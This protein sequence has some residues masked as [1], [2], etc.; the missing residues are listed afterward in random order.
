MTNLHDDA[1]L[2]L[3]IG[4]GDAAAYRS[5]ADQHLEAI[6]KYAQRLLRSP[7]EA[8]DVAQETFLRLWTDAAS[9]TPEARVSAWLHRIAHNLC[10]DRLRKMREPLT[11]AVEQ[12]PSADRPG[13]LFARKQLAEQVDQVLHALPERQR[14]AIT[15]V[16]YQGMTNPEA[17]LVLGVGVEAVES[18]LSRARRTLRRELAGIETQERGSA[19]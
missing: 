16:H 12:A 4:R 19:P 11:D 7:S 6:M 1:A 2:M 3:R 9:W 8:E 17:A 5:V 10:M 14:A 18:L 15:L 13:Q